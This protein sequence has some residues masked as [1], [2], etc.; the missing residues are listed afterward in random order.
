MKNFKIVLLFACLLGLSTAAL[1]QGGNGNGNN[2][3]AFGNQGNGNGNGNNGNGNGNGGS[4][5]TGTNSNGNNGNAYGNQGNGN[6]QGNN[7]NGN[8]NGGSN[9]N[10]GI[11]GSGGGSSSS[12]SGASY[13]ANQS[14]H[15]A[16]SN[17]IEI[18]FYNTGSATGSDVTIP[19]NTVNDYANGVE[20]NVQSLKVR[21][22]KDF[23]VA[24]KTNATNFSYSGSTTPA[25]VM[26][27]SGV[28]GVMVTS[29]N[30]GGSI[31]N[32]FSN[33]AYNTLT[34]SNQNLISNADRGGNQNFSV[35]Y[36]ATPGFAYPAGTYTVDVVYTA[37]QN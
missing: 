9:N 30:T 6:G 22:N 20:T 14:T 23:T 31:G 28:L 17:A 35:K 33:S 34:S 36:K 37:T 26:P 4:N 27:V 2:G 11:G 13:G 25:P 10:S 7:G 16:L 24:V 32:N 21:S 29:N 15:L 1:A 12:G 18:T 5:N 19:F 8:G 3:N